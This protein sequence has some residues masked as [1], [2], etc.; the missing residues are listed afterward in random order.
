[1]QVAEALRAVGYE[2]T[3]FAQDYYADL[4]VYK[5]PTARG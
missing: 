3:R 2:T 4:A 1:M 5:T